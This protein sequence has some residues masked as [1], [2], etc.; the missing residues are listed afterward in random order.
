[1]PSS[2]FLNLSKLLVPAKGK[3]TVLLFLYDFDKKI[4]GREILLPLLEPSE[5][6]SVFCLCVKLN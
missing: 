5:V 6:F 1:M 4:V 3:I 2:F